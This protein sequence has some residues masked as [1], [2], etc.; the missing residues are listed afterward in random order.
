MN[1]R[2]KAFTLIELLVVISIIALLMAIL[3]PALSKAREQGKRMLCANN[4]KQCALA[5]QIYSQQ[6]RGVYPLQATTEWA[7]DIS[8]WTTDLII[9]SGAEPDIFYC[10]SNTKMSADKD[11]YWR[12]AEIFPEAPS[13]SLDRE[14]PDTLFHRRNLYRVSSYFWLFDSYDVLNDKDAGRPD[15]EGRPT[16]DWLVKSQDVENPAERKMI[17]DAVF[18]QNELYTQIKGGNWDGWKKTDRTNHV[19]G[20]GDLN[21]SNAAFADGHVEWLGEEE[22][23]NPDGTDRVRLR[24]GGSGGTVEQIW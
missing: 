20:S 18:K 5:A 22:L 4:L 24:V 10:P 12:F 1:S 9:E 13:T 17:A 8:Y 16:T 7:W 19:D 15:L 14:E 3:M 23:E 21:G 6:N 2:K 11:R